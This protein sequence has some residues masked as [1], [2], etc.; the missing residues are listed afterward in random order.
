MNE[1][2]RRLSTLAAALFVALL[3]AS[4]WL[5]VIGAESINSLLQ[6]KPKQAGQTLG[7][8]LM[9]STLGI[10][11]IFDPASD[12]KLP[13]RNE[14]F[15]Q[16]L[17]VWGWKRSRYVE[18]PLFGPPTSTSRRPPDGVSQIRNGSSTTSVRCAPPRCAARP[19]RAAGRPSRAST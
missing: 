14:D 17:G 1:P 4:T 13:R 6:G 7:R 8:F 18:L 5:Q 16:T 15:G 11:G 12:A 19:W 9:N 3:V 2:I 10:G